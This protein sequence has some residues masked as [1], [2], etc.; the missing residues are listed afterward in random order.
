MATAVLTRSVAER[1]RG[2]IGY[3][4]GIVA[5]IGWVASVFPILRE[6]DAFVGFI[7][8][9][10][11]EMLA[12]FGIDPAT[13][14]TAAGYL[15]AQ[16]YSLFGPLLIIFFT[17][18]GAAAA[19]AGEERAQTMDLL[20]A[21]PVSRR[22][23]ILEKWIAV[24]GGALAIVGALTVALL[25][26]NPVLDL[27]L[28]VLPVIATNLALWLLACTIGAVALA[29][30]SFTGTPT[31]ARGVAGALAFVAWLVNGF[32]SI[33]SW[34]EAPSAVSPFTWYMD[35]ELLIGGWGSGHTWLLLATLVLTAAAVEL[36]SRRDLAT[37]AIV[38][39]DRPTRKRRSAKRRPPRSA[40][41]LTDVFRKTLWD[42]RR[43][44]W[45]WILGF[46]S[47]LLVTFAAWPA[48]SQDADA[49]ASLITALP[50]EVFALFGM[51][52]PESLTTPAGFIS[53]RSYL[54]IGP[55]LIVLFAVGAVGTGVIK[56]E[57]SGVLDAVLATPIA[58][59]SALAA[60][61]AGIAVSL[62]VIA[63]ALVVIALISDLTWSTG[64]SVANIVAANVGLALL[65]LCFAGVALAVWSMG[66]SRF[67]ATRVTA[68]VAV[69]TYFMNGLGSLTDGL[70]PLRSL[71]P[72]FWY[73]G[74]TPPLAKGLQP[75]YLLLLA[76]GV[77]G[78]LLA[79]RRFDHRDLAA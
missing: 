35:S 58:R 10:P 63:A 56:E 41:L 46:A 15:S 53:S 77:A 27:A 28:P 54:S 23:V 34:L 31:A 6:S 44:I 74:D 40:W 26:L 7:E 78:S 51:T 49:L 48:L 65:G 70:A 37:E 19:T 17:I 68:V 75:A 30:G 64:L 14:L 47:L 76:V 9:F 33:Y 79:V 24:V 21:N 43:G 8:D 12:L 72:F 62:I 13:Y 32:S 39:P 42:R 2:L 4:V 22:R 36:F 1:R 3:A 25:L 11:T 45:G 20:L 71:S 57:S 55:I 60:K 67:S 69:A 73:L 50:R 61:V 59:R 66:L 52:N 18:G 5:L 38:I 29:V 16:F